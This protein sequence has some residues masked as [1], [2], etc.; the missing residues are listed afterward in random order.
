MTPSGVRQPSCR[1]YAPLGPSAMRP[2]GSPAP[3]TT[4]RSAAGLCH[5][6]PG[7]QSQ[8]SQQS[9]QSKRR[10]PSETCARLSPGPAGLA[11]IVGCKAGVSRT[12][13][14][15]A[16]ALQNVGAPT[17]IRLVAQAFRPEGFP[18]PSATAIGFKFLT[19]EGVSHRVA[20]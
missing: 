10:S 19:P 2:S 9:K 1:R 16:P 18:R 7:R 3:A 8:Q 11:L 5:F 12:G 15:W 14:S 4:N 20:A 13:G 6:G 17:E